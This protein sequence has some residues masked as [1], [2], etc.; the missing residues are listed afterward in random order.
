[1][2]NHLGDT[3]QAMCHNAWQRPMHMG[4]MASH[5]WDTWHLLRL[6]KGLHSWAIFTS[7]GGR[8]RRKGKEKGRKIK[9]KERIKEKKKEENEGVSHIE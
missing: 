3:W 4:H 2:A 7:K 1:M 6:Y 5:V 9:E 8:R